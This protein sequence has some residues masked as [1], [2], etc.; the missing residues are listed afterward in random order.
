MSDMRF[1][2]CMSYRDRQ[3]Q[4]DGKLAGADYCEPSFRD[5]AAENADSLK[6]YR[7]QLEE[8]GLPCEAANGMFPGEIHLVGPDVDYGRIDEFVDRG[9]ENFTSLGGRVV[10]FGSGGARHC[11]EEFPKEKAYEQLRFVCA[12][13]IAPWMKKHGLICV[14][15]PLRTQEC[16]MVYNSKIA[17]DICKAVNRPEIQLLIDLFH[18]RS[19]NEPTERLKEYRGWV[20]HVHIA[21]SMNGRLVPQADDGE[22][23]SDFFAMLRAIGYEEKRISLEGRYNDFAPD[24]KTSLAYLKTL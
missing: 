6:Q 8:I 23:Y 3:R 14:I 17:F 9:A 18:F 16:N 20:R 21:S 2:I 1:G 4:L 19:E 10:V 22:D 24:A 12:E 15:E 5:L 13:H 7:E 11:P